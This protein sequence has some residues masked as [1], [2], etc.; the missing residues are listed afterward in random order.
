M[1]R[2]SHGQVCIETKTTLDLEN[3]VGLP[4]GNIFH[5][6]LEMPFPSDHTPLDS[7]AQRWGVSSSIPGALIAGSSSRRGGGVS[8]IGGHNAAM[9]A[10]EMLGSDA[11]R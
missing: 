6:P 4:G 5:E 2:D 3:T 8:A 1:M 11:S 10:L 9:A 7:P